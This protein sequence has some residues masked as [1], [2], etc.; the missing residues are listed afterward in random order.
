MLPSMRYS[1]LLLCCAALLSPAAQAREQI[2]V[3]GST[4]VFP[5][6]AAVAEQLGREGQY[7]TPIVEATGTGGGFKT[8]CGGVGDSFP[9]LS[10]ASRP[11]KP[12]ETELC[13]KNG[14]HRIQ[15][16][17]IGYDGIVI[18]NARN[19]PPFRL[20]RNDLFLA[21]AREVPQGGAL[22]PNPYHRWRELNPTLPDVPILIYGSPPTS[23]TRDAFVE[24]VMHEGCKH[25]PEFNITYPD[26]EQR[27]QHCGTMREDGAWVE[28][29]ENGNLIIQKLTHNEAALGIF[30]YSYL[31]QNV[32]KVKA[33]DIEGVA[34]SA[35]TI[36]SGHYR[37]AR[38]LY[39]YVK[40]EHLQ[41]VSG[42]K[43]FVTHITADDATGPDGYLVLRGLLALPETEHQAMK[44]LAAAM[45]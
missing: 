31:E 36:T 23:G 15:E 27:K 29:G 30:G 20:S 44:T 39:V 11:I 17:K 38:S 25:F 3:V 5:F 8:F 28:E 6:V 16:I 4:T 41:Q 2:R 26:E 43:E 40:M 7:R 14:V 35:A 9:D 45:Q 42:L 12:A 21:L 10:N 19:A 1:A 32:E 33:A 18:A 34:P 13:H 22:V 24:L 37:L